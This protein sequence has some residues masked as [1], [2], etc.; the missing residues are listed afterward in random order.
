MRRRN[1]LL[2]LPLA[3]AIMAMGQAPV[4]KAS[5]SS[6]PR[7]LALNVGKSLVLESP[8]DIQRVSVANGETLEL[9]AVSPRE[10]V[11]NGK[12]PGESSLIL[13]QASGNRLMF[14]VTVRKTDLKQESLRREL[15]KELGDQGITATLDSDSVFL[16]GTVRDVISAERAVAIASAFGKPV[17]MLRVVTPQ[18]EPQILLKVKFAEVDRSLTVDTGWNL[19][20]TGATN[21]VGAVNTGQFSPP[22]LNTTTQSG[23]VNTQMTLSDALN[24]FM[25]RP[26]LNLGATIKL[27]QARQVLEILAEPNLLTSNGKAASFISG[28]EFP[29]PIVQAASGG[30]PI[31]TI[32]WREFGIKLDFTPNLTPRGTIRLMV[33]PEVSSLDYSNSLTYAGFTIPAI[34]T[35][36]MSTEVELKDG[37][38]FAIAGLL[39][40]RVTDVL[41]KIPGLAD[42]PFF[43]KLFQSRDRKK[44]KTELLVVVT[45]ELVRPIPEG[46]PVPELKIPVPPLE[47]GL[48]TPPRTPGVDVTG[49]VPVKPP[50][51]TVPIEQVLHPEKSTATA[52]PAPMYQLVPVPQATQAAPGSQT[53]TT[54]TQA[55][56]KQ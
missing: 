43:G 1:Y 39:D 6:T 28:G 52:A 31:V 3:M 46:Q 55:P 48:A 54:T 47:E 4:Q 7:D 17:N 41:N 38:T 13:W 49:P 2:I 18:G 15:A 5:P 21:S 11:I 32:S 12:A 23:P 35:R 37:Q 33:T 10:V 51:E 22:A 45:P 19:F 9:V 30:A 27:L 16:R 36:K 24:I 25:F 8:E 44:N 40:N 20:S 34:S 56:P 26:D 29:F 14:D 42:I 50:S 53:T